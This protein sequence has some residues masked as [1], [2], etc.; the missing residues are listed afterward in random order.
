M[1]EIPAS[2]I[3][4]YIIKIGSEEET[5]LNSG[6]PYIKISYIV[7]EKIKGMIRGWP[8]VEEARKAWESSDYIR[9]FG[10]RIV[11]ATLVEEV[12]EELDKCP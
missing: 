4:G 11:K 9:G 3:I 1:S 12:V 10:A 8:T 2:K 5:V 6:Q 7:P